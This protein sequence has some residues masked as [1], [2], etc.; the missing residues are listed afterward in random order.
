VHG[1][2][3]EKGLE[4]TVGLNGFARD[5]STSPRGGSIS[6]LEMTKGTDI[7]TPVL[8]MKLHKWDP[9]TATIQFG[10]DVGG[11]GGPKGGPTCA[12]R[13]ELKDAVAIEL[14]YG[15]SQEERVKWFE[16]EGGPQS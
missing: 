15:A 7:A 11:I 6:A 13:F 8:I 9:V 14:S 12:S 4:G 3:K 10:C 1:E 2:V 5:L 16:G